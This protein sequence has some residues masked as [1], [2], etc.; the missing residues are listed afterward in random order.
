[1]ELTGTIKAIGQTQQVNDNFSKREFVIEVKNGS[2]TDL[3]ALQFVKDRTNKLD[4][5]NIGD[6]IRVHFNIQ[7]KEYNGRYFTNLTAWGI[8][9]EQQ[10]AQPT[11]QP[12]DDQPLP[13]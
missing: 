13:F 2:Y 8:A 12:Q 11:K 3:V 6:N 9:K 7:S 5:Y 4:G 10:E 1:M